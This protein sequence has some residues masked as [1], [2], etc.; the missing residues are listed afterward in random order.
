MTEDLANAEDATT[1][2]DETEKGALADE[3]EEEEDEEEEEEEEK[4]EEEEEEEEEDADEEEIDV[5]DGVSCSA[6]A[7]A[8]AK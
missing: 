1:D 3:E 8:D 6:F 2:L 7:L 5:K 4:E